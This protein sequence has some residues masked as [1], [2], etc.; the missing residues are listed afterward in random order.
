MNPGE[1]PISISRLDQGAGVVRDGSRAATDSS[2]TNSNGQAANDKPA[3]KSTN[4]S[5]WT[6]EASEGAADDVIYL[7]NKLKLVG[8]VIL[9]EKGYITIQKGNT[10]KRVDEQTVITVLIA[11]N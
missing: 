3:H 6:A 8:R 4:P 2:G 10:S 1:P 11:P 5:I 9:I 7:R